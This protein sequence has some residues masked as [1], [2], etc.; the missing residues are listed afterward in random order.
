MVSRQRLDQP[1]AITGIARR[2]RS[3]ERGANLGY[4]SIT[5]GGMR[6]AS[7]D[8]LLVQ[9]VAGGLPGLRITGLE[10]VDGTLRVTG[11][12]EG[13]GT[14]TWTG[15]LN[16]AG[17]TNLRGPV[18]ITGETGTLTVD[19]ET[20]LRGIT[21]MLADLR[22]EGGGKITVTG[23]D[24]DTILTNS[25]IQFANGGIVATDSLGGISMRVGSVRARVAAGVIQLTIGT[26]SIV[27]N[28]TGISAQFA[29]APLANWPGRA[30]GDLV[31][32]AS[33]DVFRI[34]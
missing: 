27:I 2:L 25:Q 12:I 3:A 10:V 4:S 5:R 14:F 13:S 26:R 11:T 30:V 20:L 16:Q 31:S 1:G 8:G 9:T 7:A 23:A 17:A 33:G 21:R 28:S 19:A 6:V 22:V 32:N 34:V 29:T 18:A 24:G 15:T